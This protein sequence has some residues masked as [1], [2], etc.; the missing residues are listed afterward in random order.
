MLNDLSNN[1]NDNKNKKSKNFILK[2]NINKWKVNCL[3]KDKKKKKIIS[4]RKNLNKMKKNKQVLKHMNKLNKQKKDNILLKKYLDKWKENAFNNEDSITHK[5]IL[6]KIINYQKKKQQDA[7]ELKNEKEKKNILLNKLKK[8]LLQSLLHIYKEQKNKLL[9]KYL[10][11]W[12]QKSKKSKRYVRKILI[13][14]KSYKSIGKND[15]DLSANYSNFESSSSRVKQYNPKKTSKFS[16]IERINKK[17]NNALNI[18]NIKQNKNKIKN[19]YD[20]YDRYNK[21]TDSNQQESQNCISNNEILRNISFGDYKSFENEKTGK[22][23]PN[24]ILDKI[25]QRTEK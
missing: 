8:T 10:N 12:K 1:N 15:S 4:V 23:F 19:K 11:K 18:N 25:K 3:N 2:H 5:N 9:K 20:K 13:G 22:F 21:K 6:Q 16:S 17:N 14:C 24:K 7:L